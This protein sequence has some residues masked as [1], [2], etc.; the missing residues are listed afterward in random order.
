MRLPE[1]EG[2]VLIIATKKKRA[3]FDDSALFFSLYYIS[4]YGAGKLSYCSIV[5]PHATKSKETQAD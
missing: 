1:R 3:E 2:A 4:M 5:L